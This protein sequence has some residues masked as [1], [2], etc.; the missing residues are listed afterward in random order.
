VVRGPALGQKGVVQVTAAEPRPR[1]HVY[2]GDGKGKT[3]SCVGLAV[4]A[5]GAGRKVWLIQFDKGY[6]GANEHYSERK[7]L[8]TLP[9][10]RL[11]PTGCERMMP[12]GRFRFGVKEEDLDEARRGLALAREAVASGDNDLVILDEVLSAERYHLIQ[13]QDV[14]ELVAI[15]RE[16]GSAELVLSGRTKLQSILDAADLV[17]EMK[18]VKHYFDDG[19]PARLGIEF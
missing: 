7:I 4:R 17:T 11:D 6:D 14:L 8:R 18:K 10:L 1:L 3:T 15:W 2:T 9:G 19:L 5:L 13:E 16:R 12:T